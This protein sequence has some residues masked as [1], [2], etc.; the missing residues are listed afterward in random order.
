VRRQLPE[1]DEDRQIRLRQPCPRR[2]FSNGTYHKDG[3]A[4]VQVSCRIHRY[5]VMVV[6]ADGKQFVQAKRQSRGL[7]LMAT[8]GAALFEL[9]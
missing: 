1:N 3:R 5:R 7:P 9:L 2:L 8:F 6:A 4:Q